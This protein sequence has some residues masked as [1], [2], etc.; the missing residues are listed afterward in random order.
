[1]RD[2]EE[3]IYEIIRGAASAHTVVHKVRLVVSVGLED[4]RISVAHDGPGASCRTTPAPGTPGSFELED[5]R[6]LLLITSF[7]DQVMF[8]Q[9][10]NEIVM[11]KNA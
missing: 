6:G 5:C 1:M 2:D 7:M 4:T 8:N 10:R 3:K 11:V 9:A